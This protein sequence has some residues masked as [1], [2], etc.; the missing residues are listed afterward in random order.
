MDAERVYMA[1]GNGVS[2]YD[3]MTAQP[4]RREQ[5]EDIW[6]TVNRNALYQM[7]GVMFNRRYYLAFPT[8]DSTVN[9]AMLIYDLNEGTILFYKGIYIENFLSSK[10]E[11]Y[12]TSSDLP[13]RILEV[14]YDSWQDGAACGK[15]TKWT[16]PWLDFGY[17]RI[18][19]GGFDL[20]M[21][22]EVQD[23]EVTLHITI[24]TEKKAKSKDYV[25]K[26]AG[27]KTHRNKKL[28]FGGAGRRFR[29]IIE[30]AAGVTAPWRL[31]GGI[32]MVVETDPD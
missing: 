27:G 23:E 17:K 4:F 18:Q 16:S 7:V 19:K 9:N 29:L 6:R 2:I 28:H 11:L 24:E 25:I 22:P 20:Y 26:P 5:V 13:G 3:G 15:A 8:G 1:D 21:T 31:V 14:R 12:A 10:N 32:Q 30:T